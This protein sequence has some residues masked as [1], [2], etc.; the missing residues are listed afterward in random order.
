MEKG[1]SEYTFQLSCNPE[2][3]NNV[4]QGFITGNNYELIQDEKEQYYR[5]G[6]SM[7]GSIFQL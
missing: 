1:R 2:V 7:Q 6:N 3:A 4:V 5:A